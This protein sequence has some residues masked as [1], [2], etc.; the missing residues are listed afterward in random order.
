LE[1]EDEKLLNAVNE[2]PNVESAWQFIYNSLSHPGHEE[3]QDLPIHV[4]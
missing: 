1:S 3:G 2:I 4:T